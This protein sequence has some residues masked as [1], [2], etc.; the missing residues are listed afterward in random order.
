MKKL[1][2]L[3]LILIITIFTFT[4]TGCEEV[5]ENGQPVYKVHE[6]VTFVVVSEQN[7]GFDI[8]V[9]KETKVMYI[10]YRSGNPYA[11]SVMLDATGKP[12]LWKGE[13]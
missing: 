9:H 12:L 2:T 4:C 3:F 7:N 13:L 10:R 5:N 11:L 8:L 6:D 1:L